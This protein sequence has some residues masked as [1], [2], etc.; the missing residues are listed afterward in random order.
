MDK[1]NTVT[2][3]LKLFQGCIDLGDCLMRVTIIMWDACTCFFF[4]L[5][6]T[7]VQQVDTGDA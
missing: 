6:G 2:L 3:R 7:V 4:F 1:K 5:V